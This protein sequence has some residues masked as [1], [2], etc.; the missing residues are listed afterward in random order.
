MEG[1]KHPSPGGS[2][3][4]L[5]SPFQVVKRRGSAPDA[6][7]PSISGRP[8]FP[9]Y[10]SQ[11]SITLVSVQSRFRFG[12]TR[13]EIDCGAKGTIRPALGQR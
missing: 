3:H 7:A 10:H 8:R 9:W 13:E 6:P 1:G 2:V 5:G 11:K 12:S 4:S